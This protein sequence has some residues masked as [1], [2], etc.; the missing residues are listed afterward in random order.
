MVFSVAGCG[1]ALLVLAPNLALLV[2][3]PRGGGLPPSGA[4]TVVVLLERA[5][6]AACLVLLVFS[7]ATVH[8]GAVDGWLVVAVAAILA[9]WALWLRYL[10]T[11]SVWSLFAPVARVPIPMA[12][13]PVLCF[14]A[15]A[16]WAH[17]PWLFGASVVLAAGHWITSW[18]TYAVLRAER[19][20]SAGKSPSLRSPTTPR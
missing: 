11:R 5:G 6:Q 19:D 16:G 7:G 2:A 9:Y 17:S 15:A 4:G 12:L 13:L 18:R 10:R 20:A 8:L 1:V 14:A 3:P